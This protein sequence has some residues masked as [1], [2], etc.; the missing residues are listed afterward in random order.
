MNLIALSLLVSKSGPESVIFVDVR[1]EE[2][3]KLLQDW[4]AHNLYLIWCHKNS[5]ETPTPEQKTQTTPTL[6]TG[7]M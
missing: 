2:M 6:W 1:M 3:K 5:R 7:R 4:I